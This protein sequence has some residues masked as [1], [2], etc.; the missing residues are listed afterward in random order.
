MSIRIN[1]NG[2]D[3]FL[4]KLR[5]M[6]GSNM[7][8]QFALWL[9]AQGFEFIDVIQD[10]IKRLETVDTR[11]LFNSFD[12]GNDGNIW[13]IKNGGLTLQIGTNVKYAK[14]VNDGHWTNPNGVK[15]RWV[16][17]KWKG[18]R[19]EYDPG[20]DTGMLLKQQW[21]EGQP[22]WDNAIAIYKRLFA[23]SFERKFQQW[24]QNELG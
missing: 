6:S 12:K 24:I 18:T 16:P 2:M 19:F 1:V 5:K 17:G 3:Q 7:Q 15:T 9:E 10:E 22:Y 21:I 14:A 4:K 20:A 23:A 8:Q 11:R 13:Q